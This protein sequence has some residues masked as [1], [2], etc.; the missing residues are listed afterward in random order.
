[1]GRARELGARRG[2]R[3]HRW[4]ARRRPAAARRRRRR[5]EGHA[6]RPAHHVRVEPDGARRRRAARH[7]TELLRRPQPRR[8]HRAHRH[9]RAGFDE[10]VRLVIERADAMH[11]AGTEQPG[12]D[13]RRPRPRRRPGRG[14]L[15]PRRRGRVGG[16]LQRARPGRH[17]RLARRRRRG[18]R[19]RQ[20]ARRQEGDGRC[21]CPARSTRRSWRRR[22]TGCAR[23]SPTP[24]PRDTEVPV[25]SNVD[26]L[27]HDQ[28][29]EWASLLSAQLS[30]PG[31]LEA[32]PARRSPTLGRHRVRRARPRRR[33]HRHG[34]AHRRRRPRRSRVPT[35]EDLDKLLEWSGAG[36]AT[37][38]PRRSKASTCSPAE[39]LVVSP[40]AGVFSPRR[41]ASPTGRRSTS[42]PCSA[43]SAA[44]RCAR[45]S[46]ACSRATSPCRRRARHRPPADRLAAH[47]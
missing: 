8:V 17:R 21:R 11:D 1:M 31:A 40:A 36:V 6:Q 27:P 45:R 34:Q 24:T 43:T 41:R 38:S 29:E 22:A 19:A 30:Q 47:Q 23:R 26:A 25:V 32:L 4:P 9:R 35:P 44:R 39:R 13:G 15:P 10:G 3:R 33:A 14:R 16:Q 37:R 18:E 12:H 46:P 7:R 28:G 2:G 42:A 20:G 5:A